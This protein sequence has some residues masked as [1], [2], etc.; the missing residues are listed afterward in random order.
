[1][2]VQRGHD[3][4]PGH[5]RIRGGGGEE[6]MEREGNLEGKEPG[7]LEEGKGTKNGWST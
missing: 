5:G 1:M 3:S 7:G 4:E 2:K 6:E